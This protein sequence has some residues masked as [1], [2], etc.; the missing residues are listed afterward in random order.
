MAFALLDA[1]ISVFPCVP[2]VSFKSYSGAG[3]QRGESEKVSLCVI[4]LRGT[5]W[6]SRISFLWLNPHCF[7]QP[8]ILGTYLPGTGTLS[9]GLVWGWDSSL[10]RYPSRIFIHHTWMWD[11]PKPIPCL[12]PSYQS[13]RC[14][15]FNSVV[16]R[17]PFSSI[18][19]GSE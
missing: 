12:H 4:S 19:D 6:G 1:R 13:D 11:Q 10:L 9:W 15:F 7:L 17:L 5:A 16:V 14:G 2:L 18:S 3:A 8:Y